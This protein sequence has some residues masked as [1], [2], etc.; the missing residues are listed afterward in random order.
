M[1]QST[2]TLLIAAPVFCVYWLLFDRQVPVN[3]QLKSQIGVAYLVV[4]GSCIGHTLYFLCVAPM[5]FSGHW[6][7]NFIKS[8][9]CSVNW[10]LCAG[11]NALWA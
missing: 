6:V 5:F 1:R 3:W 11:R 2:G 10:L 8:N 7:V 4:A 9:G